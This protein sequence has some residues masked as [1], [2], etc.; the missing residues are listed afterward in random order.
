MQSCVVALH[1]AEAA[2]HFALECQR[3]K[4]DRIQIALACI[5]ARVSEAAGT[6]WAKVR[7]APSPDDTALLALAA[8]MCQ[9]RER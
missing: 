4:I 5:G 9:T 1:S 3:L 6:G 8:E 2:R 7:S